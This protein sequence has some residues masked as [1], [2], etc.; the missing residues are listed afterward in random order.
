MNT[1]SK[2]VHHMML[3]ASRCLINAGKRQ[4]DAEHYAKEMELDRQ[5]WHDKFCVS[6]AE[7]DQLREA[8]EAERK[9]TEERVDY[10]E[11]T[12]VSKCECI[13]ELEQENA[14]L[15]STISDLTTD[16]QAAAWVAEHPQFLSTDQ[17]PYGVNA[18]AVT[19]GE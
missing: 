14:K 15:Q 5:Y 12:I 1:E 6:V 16:L 17:K 8:L 18:M 4:R 7:M 19:G 13:A 2:I 3:A 11:A 9:K 10:L